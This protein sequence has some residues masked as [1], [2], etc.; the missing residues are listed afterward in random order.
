[1]IVSDATVER[2]R[3][4]RGGHVAKDSMSKMKSSCRGAILAALG[5]AAQALVPVSVWAFQSHP[6]PEG[7]YAHQLA[8]FF[9]IIAMGFLAYWLEFNRLV[10]Q[11]GWRLI[12]TSCL[13]F[14]LWNVVAIAGHWVEER[15]PREALQGDPDWTQRIDLAASTMNYAYYI[16]KLDHVVCVPALTC[17]FLGVRSLYKRVVSKEPLADE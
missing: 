14:V 2:L 11:K 12:Q 10:L 4:A 5:V 15:I 6:A 3:P 8:H 1:V 7:L 13:L 9:L 17:L 16:L